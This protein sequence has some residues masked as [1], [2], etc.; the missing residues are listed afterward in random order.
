MKKLISLMAI[1]PTFLEV[2]IL[3]LA[4]TPE[5]INIQ[6]IQEI[7]AFK[8][9]TA[10]EALAQ[11]ITVRLLGENIAGSGVI[12]YQVES[13][14]FVLT[15]AHVIDSDRE[16]KFVVLT[17]DGKEY[18][19]QK[20]SRFNFRDIDLAVVKFSTNNQYPVAVVSDN[21][22]LSLGEEVYV[23]GFPNYEQK[24]VNYIPTIDLG[25]K[26]YNFTKG[27]V[28]HVLNLPLEKGYKIG[29]SN[30]I[31]VGMSGGP[32]LNQDGEL[33]GIIGRT[34]YG[35]GGLDAY[36]FSDGSQPSEELV[37]EFFVASWAIP[38]PKLNLLQ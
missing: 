2:C 30:D 4:S 15:C 13:D 7:S 37:E 17:S 5:G 3:P 19:A 23:T 25:I 20:D 33:V 28:I 24:S 29:M 11:P 12:I 10:V 18:T 8:S 22:N 1:I 34:K 14:Y 26:P 6:Q 32:V 21:F 36:R 38:I 9:N 31:E 27:K 16:G 35:F